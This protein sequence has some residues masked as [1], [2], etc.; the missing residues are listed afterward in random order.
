MKGNVLSF[1]KSILTR[2]LKA[3]TKQ[4]ADADNDPTITYGNR[5]HL[6]SAL[7]LPGNFTCGIVHLRPSQVT[8]H[9]PVLQCT[10]C[11]KCTVLST[12][13][14]AQIARLVYIFP[15]LDKSE[16]VKT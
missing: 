6:L 2:T 11:L 9:A 10:S 1:E 13:I 4:P 12:C 8:L 3:S 14:Q 15:S 5:G 7:I 16:K